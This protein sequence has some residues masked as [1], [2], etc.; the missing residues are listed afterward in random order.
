VQN[1]KPYKKEKYFNHFIT[2]IIASELYYEGSILMIE[3]NNFS[4]YDSIVIELQ[5]LKKSTVLFRKKFFFYLIINQL[6]QN[7]AYLF[8]KMDY[9]YDEVINEILNHILE[10][11]KQTNNESFILDFLRYLTLGIIL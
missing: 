4:P 2:Q 3:F 5:T 8:V 7:C 10:Q 1:Y 11:L 6:T 9:L